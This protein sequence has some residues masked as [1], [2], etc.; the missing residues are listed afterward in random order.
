MLLILVGL[1]YYLASVKNGEPDIY[2]KKITISELNACI[3]MV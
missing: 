1:Y 2:Y 3:M